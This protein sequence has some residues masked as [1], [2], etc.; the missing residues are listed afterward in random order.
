MAENTSYKTQ[1]IIALIGLI[2]VVSAALI[3]SW[4]KIFLSKDEPVIE[5]QGK[6]EQLFSQLDSI[7]E[8]EVRQG[9][10]KLSLYFDD[11]NSIDLVFSRLKSHLSLIRAGH[12]LKTEASQNYGM[13]K[14]Q[15]EKN[16][17]RSEEAH[18]APLLKLIN[19]FEKDKRKTL[20]LI[21]LNNRSMI[22]GRFIAADELCIIDGNGSY[23]KQLLEDPDSYFRELAINALRERQQEFVEEVLIFALKKPDLRQLAIYGLGDRQSKNAVP[24]L[25]KILQDDS[26]DYVRF[27]AYEVLE[28][29]DI[30]TAGQFP[31]PPKP[32]VFLNDN[33]NLLQGTKKDN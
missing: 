15:A 33:Q 21:I 2:G 23:W 1:I 4:D 11:P 28:R 6:I 5:R 12:D 32:P 31:R 13:Y 24:Y 18:I 7:N 20:Y 9:T 17:K 10:I 26:N 3:S 30:D 29:L 27:A 16:A 22:F 25:V 8:D 14:E 19:N